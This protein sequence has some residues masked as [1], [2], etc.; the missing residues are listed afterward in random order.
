MRSH[1]SLRPLKA[2]RYVGVFGPE[3]MLCLAVVRVG[4]ARQSFWAVWDR[5]AQRLHER[6]A[7]GRGPVTLAPGSA[8]VEDRGIRLE[9]S[10]NETGGIECVCPSG[11]GYVWTR[12]QGG[13]RASGIL[14]LDGATRVFEARAVIDDTAGYHTRHTSWRWSAGVGE[15]TDGREVAWNLVA[16]VNDPPR[17]SE[18]TVWIDRLPT[19]PPP[20]AFTEQG[21]DGLRFH[22]EATRAHKDNFVL[23]R[24]SYSQPFGTFSGALPGGVELA[25]GYGVTETHDA[26]W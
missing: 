2:W 19:E 20:S 22:A 26:R 4:R 17:D 6:T 8:R 3:L 7:L 16:G 25:A 15:A 23:V 1:R 9:L 18:R 12:K 5:E 24:S 21:V 11:D 14:T 13:V 10:L